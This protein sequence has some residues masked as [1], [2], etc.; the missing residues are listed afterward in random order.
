MSIINNLDDILTFAKV[1]KLGSFQSA[2]TA[3]NI[4]TS[5]VSKRVTR[6]EQQLN[7]KLMHRSTRRLLLTETGETYYKYIQSIP[8]QLQSA[9]EQTIPLNDAMQGELQIILPYGFDNS[10][11]QHVLPQYM[12][13]FPSVKFQIRVVMSPMDHLHQ[14]FDLLVSGKQP[15]ERLPD[16]S[17]MCRKLMNLPAGVYASKKYLEQNKRPTKPQDLVNHPCISFIWAYE[18]PFLDEQGDTY[19]IRVNPI[20]DSNSSSLMSGIT[21]NGLGICYGF[22]FMF[23]EGLEDGSIVRLLKKHTPKTLLEVY[24]FYPQSNY[25]PIKTRELI[26]RMLDTYKKFRE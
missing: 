16:T 12:K 4:S 5:L 2:A 11:K 23:T 3:L 22:D 14:S 7:A 24:L 25:M 17:L 6:L 19:T 1:A 9:Y 26:D 13:D 20:F 21:E 8:D 15:H 10:V 18:W